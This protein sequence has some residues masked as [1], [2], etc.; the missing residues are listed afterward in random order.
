MAFDTKAFKERLVTEQ[1]KS[2]FDELLGYWD[3]PEEMIDAIK[4]DHYK[5]DDA[6]HE[7]ADSNVAIYYHDIIEWYK[8]HVNEFDDEARELMSDKDNIPKRMQICQYAYNRQEM[9]NL[10]EM[11]KEAINEDNE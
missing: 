7:I 6:I 3:S 9:Q 5:V 1:D 2:F 8:E 10:V 11:I 4:A